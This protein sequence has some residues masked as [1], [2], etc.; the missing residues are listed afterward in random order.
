[1]RMTGS[2]ELFDAAQLFGCVSQ[3]N[4]SAKIAD[5]LVSMDQLLSLVRGSTLCAGLFCR[6]TSFH[7]PS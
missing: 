1:M 6:A 4:L 7:I 2:G 5:L 3:L